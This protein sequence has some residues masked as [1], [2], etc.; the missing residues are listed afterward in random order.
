QEVLFAALNACMMV[1]Y[2]VGAAAKGITLEKLELDTDGELDLRGFLGLDPDI[3]PGYESIRY[4]V[5][6][7]GN[8]T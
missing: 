7:K 8:G 6:I 4:T 5:R 3:P 2:A 1:G